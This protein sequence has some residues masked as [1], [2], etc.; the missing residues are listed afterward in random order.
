[1]A[2]SEI[3]LGGAEDRPIIDKTRHPHL[4][5]DGIDERG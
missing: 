5:S 1:M 3:P 2:R 4:N